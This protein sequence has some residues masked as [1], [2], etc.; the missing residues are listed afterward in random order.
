MNWK[1]IVQLSLSGVV[2]G[3]F[4]FVAGKILKRKGV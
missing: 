4:S 2:L 1:L 3:L